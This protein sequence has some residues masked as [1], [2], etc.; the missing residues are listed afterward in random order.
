MAKT[1]TLIWA[2]RVEKVFVTWECLSTKDV[3]VTL[4]EGLLTVEGAAVAKW[5]MGAEED[6]NQSEGGN[7]K[8]PRN[9]Y[10]ENNGFWNVPKWPSTHITHDEFE[11]GV[12]HLEARKLTTK[13]TDFFQN[14]SAYK[15]AIEQ[16][17][18]TYSRLIL[19][20][21][22]RNVEVNITITNCYTADSVLKNINIAEFVSSD[23]VFSGDLDEI[24]KYTNIDFKSIIDRIAK[25]II[26]N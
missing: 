13:C 17:I 23:N 25:S 9:W 11:E 6:E 7:E 18:R 10:Y 3:N 22:K 8:D 5:Q 1:P 4:S 19:L 2:Q 12:F 20:L 24:Y 26:D 16:L 15:K 14:T 21:K